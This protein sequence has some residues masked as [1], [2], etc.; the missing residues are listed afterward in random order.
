MYRAPTF[1]SDYLRVSHPRPETIGTHNARCFNYAMRC[2][3]KILIT[4]S[5]NNFLQPEL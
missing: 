1:T 2:H 5:D 4:T 3:C